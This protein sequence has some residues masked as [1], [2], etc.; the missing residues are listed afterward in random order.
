MI[1]IRTGQSRPWD[2][3]LAQAKL[4][5]AALAAKYPKYAKSLS[6]WVTYMTSS[7]RDPK[8]LPLHEW[9][10]ATKNKVP[11]ETDFLTWFAVSRLA[12]RQPIVSKLQP[13]QSRP[14]VT[15][16]ANLPIDHQRRLLQNFG[17][18]DLTNYI[19]L[20]AILERYL[21][22]APGE[23]DAT[24]ARVFRLRSTSARVGRLTTIERRS[25]QQLYLEVVTGNGKFVGGEAPAKAVTNWLQTLKREPGINLP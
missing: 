23:L 4:E 6:S 2:R 19:M 25:L 24:L 20:R 5:E 21:S 12:I 7:N 15:T 13:L 14:L 22:L 18:F 3:T 11:L 1:S 9:W 10:E 16:V 8:Y 17:I